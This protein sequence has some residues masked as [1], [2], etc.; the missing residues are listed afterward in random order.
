VLL[1]FVLPDEDID[2]L[3]FGFSASFRTATEEWLCEE[4]NCAAITKGLYLKSAELEDPGIS[5]IALERALGLPTSYSP[6]PDSNDPS[7]G[8][9]RKPSSP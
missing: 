7:S 9:V 5:Y 2:R 6:P 8:A 4:R 3:F 1:I